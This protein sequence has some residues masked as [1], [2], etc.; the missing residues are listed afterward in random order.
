MLCYV[1]GAWLPAEE[2]RVSAFDRGFLFGDSVYEV[3]PLYAGRPFR[4][5]AHLARL[6][7]SLAAVGIRE[8]GP[9]PP[10]ESVCA[11]LGESVAPQDGSL[12]LQVSRGSAPRQHAFPRDAEPTV[13][14]Y[15]RVREPE[16]AGAQTGLKAVLLDD[17]RWM[18]CDIKSTSLIANVL[19]TQEAVVRGADEALL[20]RDGSVNE[21]A[22]SNVFAVRSGRLLTAPL[23]H[24]IL[25]G[26]TR[27][28]VLELANA[29]GV[30]TE[31]RAIARDELLACDEVLITSSTRE[32]AAVTEIDGQ[33]VGDG[34]PGAVFRRLHAA[35]QGFKDALRA[36]GDE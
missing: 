26:I 4:L 2:A 31:E 9:E 10:W 20:V 18:R 3:I 7:A 11:R 32:V 12:Y 34:R 21:G 28:V 13:F 1:N 33:A 25:G 24:L 29:Q 16:P 30:P 15:A 6:R 17:I 19:L 35:F 36:G 23:S 8:P 14:A 22:V 27:D 5:G